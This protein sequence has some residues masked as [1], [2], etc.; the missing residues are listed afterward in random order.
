M[1]EFTKPTGKGVYGGALHDIMKDTPKQ[2]QLKII[3]DDDIILTPTEKSSTKTWHQL[4]GAVY[5][6][7]YLG[8]KMRI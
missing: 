6:K 1:P 3:T 2:E 5:I 8:V 7:K 4:S